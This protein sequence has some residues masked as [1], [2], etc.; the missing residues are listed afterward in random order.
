MGDLV[1]EE[2]VVVVLA[3]DE[4]FGEGFAPGKLWKFKLGAL[5]AK[6]IKYNWTFE[7]YAIGGT[8]RLIPLQGQ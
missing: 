4:C 8:K 1:V 6:K 2:L 3:V 7:S 5:L